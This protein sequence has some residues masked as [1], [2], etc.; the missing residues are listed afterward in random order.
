MS[1]SDWLV[2]IMHWIRIPCLW[3]SFSD[4]WQCFWHPGPFYA[5][6][7]SCST[8]TVTGDYHQMFARDGFVL[9]VG[10][11]VPSWSDAIPICYHYIVICILV[12][13][14]NWWLSGKEIKL[15]VLMKE[16]LVVFQ[17]LTFRLILLCWLASG[18][19]A[20]WRIIRYIF[21]QFTRG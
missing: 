4:I 5:F 21:G 11:W 3:D 15:W 1:A 6:R 2:D 10:I 12:T 14:F 18:H 19:R 17:W 13:I 16:A 7:I 9:C 8:K 20:N